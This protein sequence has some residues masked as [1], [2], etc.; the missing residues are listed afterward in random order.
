MDNLL[1]VIQENIS[2]QHNRAGVL[3]YRYFQGYS[4]IKRSI[5]HRPN[6]LLAT[7]GVATAA[8]ALPNRDG[9]LSARVA[10]KRDRLLQHLRGLSTPDNPASSRPFVREGQRIERAILEEEHAF[11]IE[12]VLSVQV[13]RLTSDHRSFSTVLRPIF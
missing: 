6:D 8:L 13:S 5:R 1:A 11:R 12:Q 9:N 7:K 10:A 3:S 2:Y 4:N